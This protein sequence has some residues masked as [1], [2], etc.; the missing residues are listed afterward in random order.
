MGIASD[1]SAIDT[2]DDPRENR[3]IRAKMNTKQDE[4]KTCGQLAPILL[5]AVGFVSMLWY[6]VAGIILIIVGVLWS[7]SRENQYKKLKNEIKE[8]EAQLI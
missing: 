5:V 3:V 1:L 8:L 7:N 2:P 6:W 4:I